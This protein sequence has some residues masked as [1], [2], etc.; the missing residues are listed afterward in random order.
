MGCGGKEAVLQVRQK[1]GDGKG[2]RAGAEFSL[3]RHR[4]QA[5]GI[6]RGEGVVGVEG[7]IRVFAWVREWQQHSHTKNLNNTESGEGIDAIAW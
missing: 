3:T 1:G 7:C 6:D 4:G 5:T 2:E